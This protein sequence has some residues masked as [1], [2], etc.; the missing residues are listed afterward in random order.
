MDAL[1]EQLPSLP[2]FLSPYLEREAVLSSQIEGTQSSL[3]DLLMGEATADSTGEAMLDIT[4]TSNYLKALDFGIKRLEE[5][6]PLSLRLICELHQILMSS[7]R[8]STKQP[9]EFRRSQNWIGGSRPSRAVFVPPPPQAVPSCMGELEKFIQQERSFDPNARIMP[10]LLRAAL[11]HLQF[12]TIHP[13]LDGNGRLGRMLISLILY[14]AKLL[15]QPCLYLSL[16]FKQHRDEYYQL[17]NQ[18]RLDGS[19]ELW[20][21]FFLEGVSHT[22]QQWAGSGEEAAADCR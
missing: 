18:V 17:L 7:G 11:A 4:E 8:G 19:W 5:G 10:P 13:F 20:L 1:V 9:G 16:F 2:L 15:H 12:E 22:T 3:D 21:A 14:D 6:F